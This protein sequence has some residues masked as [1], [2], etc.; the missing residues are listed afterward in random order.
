MR[1]LQ[2]RHAN[3]DELLDAACSVLDALYA[4]M[5]VAE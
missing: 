4:G 5:R 3:D 1:G 2:A